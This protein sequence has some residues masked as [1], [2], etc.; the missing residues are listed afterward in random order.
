VRF[1]ET[2]LAGAIVVEIEPHRDHRGFFAR[3]WCTREFAGSNLPTE[4]VQASLSRNDKRGTLRGMHTQLL[5]S[6]EGKLVRC[7]SGGIYDV[8]VDVRPFSKTY[9]QH[10]G[11][12][13]T[14]EAQSA[15]YIPP[16][17]LHGFQTLT[18]AAD[19]YYQMT[20]FYAP[21]LSF[22]ARWNDPAFGIRWPLAHDLT[23]TERDATYPL[24]DRAAYE[25]RVR[26]AAE[27]AA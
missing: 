15:L 7:T 21:E 11:V 9:L 23:I 12:E 18:D 17:M 1:V 13:L 6:R 26:G 2:P 27:T 10:F 8:I 3:T 14:A 22:G 16:G 24:F 5:P 20:D 25:R 19:V 4:F